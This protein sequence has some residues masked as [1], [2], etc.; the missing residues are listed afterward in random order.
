MEVKAADKT[1]LTTIAIAMAS[2][3]RSLGMVDYYAMLEIEPGAS[4]TAALQAY[5]SMRHALLALGYDQ[6]CQE[7]L[8]VKRFLQ[9]S[10]FTVSLTFDSSPRRGTP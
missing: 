7:L 9:V 4:K 3:E 5:Y 8:D 2:V 1:V 6:N 10:I